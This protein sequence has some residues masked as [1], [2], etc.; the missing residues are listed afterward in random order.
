[1]DGVLLDTSRRISGFTSG[2]GYVWTSSRVDATVD[3]GP[4]RFDVP[5]GE[6][7]INVW[8]REDG[9]I[10]DKILITTNPNYTP[11]GLGPAESG[12][13]EVQPELAISR[14]GNQIT[15]AWSGPGTLE[16]ADNILGSWTPVAGATSPFTTAATGS[17]K[18]YRLH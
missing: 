8:M 16:S 6:H 17:A 5:A 14:S 12:T 10:V 4:A 15:I 7:V 9:L 11:T 3:I 18:F 13:G 1:L 2:A